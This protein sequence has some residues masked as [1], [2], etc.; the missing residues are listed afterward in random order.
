M[1]SLISFN[2]IS[3]NV[4]F[5]EDNAK[6]TDA[7]RVNNLVSVDQHKKLLDNNGVKSIMKVHNVENPNGQNSLFHVR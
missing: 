6:M 2:H 1:A 5:N 3:L 4:Q 7:P